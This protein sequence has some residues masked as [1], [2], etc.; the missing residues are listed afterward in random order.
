MFNKEID[1]NFTVKSIQLVN[2]I[3]L[4]F[5]KLTESDLHLRSI[6]QAKANFKMFDLSFL[7]SPCDHAVST[8]LCLVIFA[9]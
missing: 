2:F 7:I 1:E 9:E 8:M 4:N 5:Q 6:L 3:I